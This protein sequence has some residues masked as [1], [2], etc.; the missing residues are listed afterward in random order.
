[1]SEN[2]RKLEKIL[3]QHE[4]LLQAA[5]EDMES[6]AKNQIEQ[7]RTLLRDKDSEMSQNSATLQELLKSKELNISDLSSQINILQ[8][9]GPTSNFLKL[10][11]WK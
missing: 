9:K 3:L 5:N 2:R 8:E 1:M 6:S 11:P 7:L 4:E 10:R